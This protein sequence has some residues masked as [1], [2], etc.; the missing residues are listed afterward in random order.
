MSKAF[1]KALDPLIRRVRLS[2]GRGIVRLVSDAG[3]IQKIQLDMRANETRSN[4]ERFQEYGFSS[5][6]LDG[7]E[8]AVVFLGGSTDHG[9]IVAV[10]DRRYRIKG[11]QGGEVAIYTDEEDSIILKRNREIHIT[12]GTKVRIETPL[13]EVTGDI[14]DRCDDQ[15]QTIQNMRDIYD[16]HTHD[17]NGEP[18]ETDPPNQLMGD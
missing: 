6:P 12:A 15:P 13:L 1:Q 5:V 18:G 3:G 4:L 16:E 8:A 9:I 10:D 7:A 2:L 17:E 14:I 11:L